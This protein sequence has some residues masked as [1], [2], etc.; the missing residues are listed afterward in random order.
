MLNYSCFL[1][2][3][4]IIAINLYILPAVPLHVQ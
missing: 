3:L 1:T 2:M 4:F